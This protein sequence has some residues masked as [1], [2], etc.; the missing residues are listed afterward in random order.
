MTYNPER[1]RKL[2]ELAN[3][4]V[5]REVYYVVSSLVSTLSTLVQ[6]CDYATQRSEGF[7]W[8]EDI[9]PLL[10]STNYEH[11]GIDTINECDDLDTLEHM[12]DSVGYWSDAL[13]KTEW[14]AIHPMVVENPDMVCLDCH[15]AL[16][17]CDDDN[18]SDEVDEATANYVGAYVGEEHD[19]EFSNCRCDCCGSLLAGA[20]FG[21]A[22][23]ADYVDQ[24][25]VDWF[26]AM[27]EVDGEAPTLKVLRNYIIENTSN[28]Q[29]FCNEN[30][31]DNFDDYRDEVYEHW[32]I[33]DWLAHKLGGMGYV[34]GDLCG[35]TIYGR[36]CT[37]QSMC[38]DHNM[39]QIAAEMW[40]EELPV[41]PTNQGA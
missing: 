34:V 23:A 6:N 12:A 24:D 8:E 39:Q 31:I 33:S 29:E 38:L 4:L 14:A 9:L 2:Q 22:T 11:A 36:C 35:L 25:F 5:Q 28:W 1:E 32:L 41:E 26:Y 20:R 7:S 18:R 13:E 16:T 10:E 3:R 19:D 17:Q 40:P 37:G 30:D 21:Y 27:Q 15:E